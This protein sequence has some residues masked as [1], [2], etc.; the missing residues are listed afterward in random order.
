MRHNQ[1]HKDGSRTKII[2]V[3]L[4]AVDITFMMI[5]N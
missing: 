4:I 3:F 2:K 5:L 1:M